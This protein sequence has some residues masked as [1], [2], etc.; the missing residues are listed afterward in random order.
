[1]A[2]HHHEEFTAGL[3]RAVAGREP[4]E[5][6]PA[7]LR[8]A[9]LAEL[10]EHSP[11]AGFM[12]PAFAR[13]VAES[14]TLSARV[15]EVHE[16]REQ[17]LAEALAQAAEAAGAPSARAAGGV[18]G[19]AAQ[20][21]AVVAA[22]HRLMFRRIQELTPAGRT[23]EEVGTL[24]RPDAEHVYGLPALALAGFPGG[25]DGTADRSGSGR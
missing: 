24:L 4:H 9:F 14:P 17:A 5:D 12:G 3:A 8:R 23:N 16:Q 21:A 25:Q 20:A 6:P 19:I 7:A 11:V 2:L 22:A 15:R 18:P 10:E 13:M 1:M